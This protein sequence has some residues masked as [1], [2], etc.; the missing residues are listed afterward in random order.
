MEEKQAASDHVISCL[1]GRKACKPSSVVSTA[2]TS[3]PLVPPSSQQ[4]TKSNSS[5]QKHTT[6]HTRS[7]T[8]KHPIP[9]PSG[10]AEFRFHRRQYEIPEQS[11][12]PHRHNPH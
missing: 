7:V 9:Q 11:F 2:S 8:Q 6:L 10:S 12:L 3:T 1:L 5:G 4:C